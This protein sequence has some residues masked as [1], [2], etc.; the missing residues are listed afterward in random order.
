MDSEYASSS[1]CARIL[2]IPF[3]KYKKVP[4]SENKKSF[5]RENIRNFFRAGLLGKNIKKTFLI[6]EKFS[7]L[8]PENALG[9]H[10]YYYCYLNTELL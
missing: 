7:R 5:F 6:R 8:R 3:P 2:N 4:F 1:K 9:R 10:I